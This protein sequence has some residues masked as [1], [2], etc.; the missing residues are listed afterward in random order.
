MIEAEVHEQLAQYRVSK[1]RE[2]FRAPLPLI[3]TV[4]GEA[5]KRKSILQS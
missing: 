3:V 4:I 5:I 1:R 2:F